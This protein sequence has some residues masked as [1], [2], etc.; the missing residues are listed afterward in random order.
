MR[1]V[2]KTTLP[3]LA[4]IDKTL[5][6]ILHTPPTFAIAAGLHQKWWGP[7]LFCRVHHFCVFASSSSSTRAVYSQTS[8]LYCWR[9][10][11]VNQKWPSCVPCQT[12]A[13]FNPG[14]PP[15]LCVWQNS[16][17]ILVEWKKKLLGSGNQC[18]WSNQ[19]FY[20]TPECMDNFAL[21]SFF[22]LRCI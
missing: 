10:S 8:R 21:G 16:R 9:A 6:E 12:I 14:R 19:I 22:L 1:Q 2:H 17:D 7:Y 5:M 3:F 15:F 20:T 18:N 13:P 11:I 4:N